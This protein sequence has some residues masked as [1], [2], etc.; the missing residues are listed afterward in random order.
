MKVSNLISVAGTKSD[1]SGLVDAGI[2]FSCSAWLPV[3]EELE[4]EILPLFRREWLESEASV[5]RYL[6][7]LL[8]GQRAV[9]PSLIETYRKNQRRHGVMHG[10]DW[11]MRHWGTAVDV[12]APSAWRHTRGQWQTVV[13][14]QTFAI[15]PGVRGLSGLFPAAL[16]TLRWIDPFSPTAYEATYQ[17]GRRWNC[18]GWDSHSPEGRACRLRIASVTAM[19]A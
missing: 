6:E 4:V 9:A 10:R 12:I 19:A 2:P 8:P 16:F 7:G 18:V 15:D 13:E 1:V 14:S 17:A 11:R 3:P 5:S